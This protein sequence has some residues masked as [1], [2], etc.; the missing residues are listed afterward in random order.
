MILHWVKVAHLYAIIVN[1]FFWEDSLQARIEVVFWH[2]WLVTAYKI[3]V[4]TS[5]LQEAGTNANVYIRLIGEAIESADI[6]LKDSESN[7]VAFEKDQVWNVLIY[8]YCL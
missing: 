7:S 8:L 5:N 1:C 3:R 2:F 4:K 6:H